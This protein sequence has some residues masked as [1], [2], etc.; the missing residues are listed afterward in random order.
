MKAAAPVVF[1]GGRALAGWWRQLAPWRPRRLWAG[2]LLLHH[3]DALVTP[4]RTARLDPFD[5]LVLRALTLSGSPAGRTVQEAEAS[6]HL[7]RQVVRQVLRNLE[8]EGLAEQGPGGDGWGTTA[9]GRQA[10]GGESYRRRAEER[11]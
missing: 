3:V 4:Q 6:L 7:G 5:R 2:T 10:L 8:A 9:L 1:P 11:R